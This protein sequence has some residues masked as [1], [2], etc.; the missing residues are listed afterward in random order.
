MK[1]QQTATVTLTLSEWNELFCHLYNAEIWYN[2]NLYPQC[3]ADCRALR[4]LIE[5]QGDLAQTVREAFAH[6]YPELR[7]QQAEA[8]KAE[9]DRL[10]GEK[11]DR[12]TLTF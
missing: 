8:R 1:T 2:E 12:E 6:D 9:R 3:K 5:A 11:A 4:Q 7:A 10:A